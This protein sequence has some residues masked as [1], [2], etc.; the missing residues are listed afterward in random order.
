MAKVAEIEKLVIGQKLEKDSYIFR[1]TTP[2]MDVFIPVILDFQ[3]QLHDAIILSVSAKVIK[4]DKTFPLELS[5][6]CTAILKFYPGIHLIGIPF[7]G[8]SDFNEGCWH[9]L[10]LKEQINIEKF[11]K[12]SR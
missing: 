5:K 10:V 3:N 12:L 9:R 8:S 2:R 4:F 7:V 6:V 1:R 11:S